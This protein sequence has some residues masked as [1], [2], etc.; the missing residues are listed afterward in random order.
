MERT[1]LVPEAMLESGRPTR[2]LFVRVFKGPLVVHGVV[3]RLHL[4]SSS[5]CCSRCMLWK[6]WAL[7]GLVERVIHVDLGM[8]MISSMP[9]GAAI[10][11]AE[12]L[13]G[14]CA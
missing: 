1:Y 4:V 13:L 10:A 8:N 12:F 3:S 2:T 6:T 11:C 14:T 7:L 5:R 9:P